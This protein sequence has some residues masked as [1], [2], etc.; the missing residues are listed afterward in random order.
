MI[1]PGMEI[2]Y[3]QMCSEENRGSLQRGMNYRLNDDYSVILMSQRSDAPYDDEILDHG[4]TI[5]YEGH[6]IRQERGGPNPKTVDQ[7][8]RSDSG[9]L[10]QNGLFY[11]AVAEYNN[12]IRNAEIVKI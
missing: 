6:D 9:N 2:S 12:S 3:Y 1:N 7:P 5:I 10:T 8:E 4:E 11:R